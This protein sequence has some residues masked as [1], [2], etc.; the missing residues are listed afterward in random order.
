MRL[1]NSLTA[2]LSALECLL[3]EICLKIEIVT[4]SLKRRNVSETEVPEAA[5][6][7]TNKV[8]VI[9]HVTMGRQDRCLHGCHLIGLNF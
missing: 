1:Q 3:T 8:Q 9:K 7:C 4:E 6:G 5:G 2:F